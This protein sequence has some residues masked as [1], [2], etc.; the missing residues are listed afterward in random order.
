MSKARNA[1]T[2]SARASPPG[3]QGAMGYAKLSTRPLHVLAFLF[4]LICVYEIGSALYLADRGHGLIETIAAHKTLARFF[5][6]FGS[7]TWFLPGIALVV[8]LLT[9]HVLERDRWQ[10]KPGVL[11]GMLVE[12]FL[13]TLPLLVFGVLLKSGDAARP[14]MDVTGGAEAPLAQLGWQ[15]KITLSIGAGLYEELLFR[16]ILIAAAHFVLVDLL[17]LR[18][19]TG[20]VLAAC[21]SAAAFTLYHDISSPAGGV[22]AQLVV[23]YAAAGLYFASVFVLRGFGIVVATH[24]IYDVV[25]LVLVGNH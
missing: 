5:E 11:L 22:D 7:A 16:L 24:A 8:V 21:I 17:R 9:W 2:R 12:S 4:P 23:F 13:W 6:A 25:V 20:G 15:A 1:G 10:I 18:S 3:R 19:V 14:A